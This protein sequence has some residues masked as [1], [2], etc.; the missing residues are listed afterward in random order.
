VAVQDSK[1]TK[2]PKLEDIQKKRATFAQETIMEFHKR[3]LNASASQSKYSSDGR[4]N[5]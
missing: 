2:L 3:N 4:L 5:H 1:D